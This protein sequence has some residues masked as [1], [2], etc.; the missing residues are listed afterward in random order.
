VAA[1]SVYLARCADDTL[2][3]GV[4]PNVIARIAAHDAG[5]GARYT[6]GRGPLALLVARR[7]RDRG[8]ALRLEHAVKQLSRPAKLAL[9]ADPRRLAALARRVQ[10]KRA[11][12]SQVG[13]ARHSTRA[14]R[15]R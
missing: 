6:R 10:R 7:C 3:C 9:A 12:A 4:T 8:A 14:P 15:A 11:R 5:R 1:W 13:S 2:Y